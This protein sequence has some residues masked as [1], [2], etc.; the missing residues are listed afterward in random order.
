MPKFVESQICKATTVFLNKIDLVT[1]EKV[2]AVRQA[3]LNIAPQETIYPS[4]AMN[5][6]C[7]EYFIALR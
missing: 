7:E 5:G 1:E 3:I 6:I 2:N 4:V